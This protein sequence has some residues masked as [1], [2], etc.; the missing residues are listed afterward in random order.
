[1]SLTGILMLTGGN[2]LLVTAEQWVDAG[3]A[4]IVVATI[5]LMMFVIEA[6]ILKEKK[7]GPLGIAGLVIGFAGVAFLSLGSHSDVSF[8]AKGILVLLVASVF[9]AAGSVHSKT[10]RVDCSLVAIIGIQML[11][12]GLGNLAIGTAFGEIPAFKLT[13]DSSLALLYLI[14]VGSIVGYSSYIYLLKHWP[15]SKASTY[16]YVNPIVAVILGALILGESI[17]YKVVIALVII[18][19]GVILVQKSKAK[20]TARS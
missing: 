15:I 20:D 17:T 2:G 19:S 8:N 14:F 7:I 3:V 11:A 10:V 13:L 5:P 1:M 6:F 16:A 12:G 9:W 4:S 18:L